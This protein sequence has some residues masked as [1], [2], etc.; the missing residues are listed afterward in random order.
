MRAMTQIAAAFA[1]GA[2]LM[3][4]TASAPR[5]YRFDSS[6]SSV[7]AKVSF[8]GI[9]NRTANFPAVTGT[10]KL[11]A[12][13]GGDAVEL[14]VR[15]DARQLTASD[16]LTTNRLKG[17]DFF[18]VANH[19]TVTFAGKR[20]TLSGPTTG[21]IDGDLTA[22]GVTRPVKLAVQFAA[23]P[24]NAGARDPISLIATTRINRR[25]FGMTAYSLIVGKNVGITINARLTPN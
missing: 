3:G 5:E 14:N 19:P 16:T 6:A 9:G 25:D 20:L 7:T 21:T 13:G 10:A 17:K 4:Q 24:A 11:T 2:L 18:D 8:L 15:I 22:R 1:I 12:S 23:P